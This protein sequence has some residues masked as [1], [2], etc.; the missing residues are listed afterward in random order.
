V[1]PNLRLP[2]RP[3]SITVRWT[4]PSYTAWWQWHMGVKT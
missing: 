4:K 3:Q 1:M 2:S